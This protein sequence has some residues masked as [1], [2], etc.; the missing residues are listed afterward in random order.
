MTRWLSKVFLSVELQLNMGRFYKID[1]TN[2]FEMSK[3]HD[4]P[5]H[6]D[7]SAT[8]RALAGYCLGLTKKYPFRTRQHHTTQESGAVWFFLAAMPKH[9]IVVCHHKVIL[10][11]IVSKLSGDNYIDIPIQCNI[12]IHTS[13][14][15]IH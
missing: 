5:A 13:G 3:P 2:L 1:C 8:Y 12:S 7:I 15:S 6:T 14:N 10:Y 11:R 4:Y 9:Q